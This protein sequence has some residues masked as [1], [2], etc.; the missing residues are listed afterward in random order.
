VCV[1]VWGQRVLEC[2]IKRI[3]GLWQSHAHAQPPRHTG[4]SRHATQM[5]KTAKTMAELEIDMNVAYE[6]SAMTEA[7]AKLTQLSGPGHVGLVNLGN[8]CYMNSVLQVCVCI[9]VC[10]RARREGRGC[11]Q[12][13]WC[14]RGRITLQR[15][16]LSPVC[17][18]CVLAVT[19]CG[20]HTR[21]HATTA[22]RAHASTHTHTHPHTS[23]HTHTV[24]HTP[25]TCAAHTHPHHT[26]HTHS[27][28][29]CFSQCLSC[30]SATPAPRP[31]SSAARP[32]TLLP[33]C[34]RSWPSS[35]WRWSRA[36]LESRRRCPRSSSP[37]RRQQRQRPHQRHPQ[38]RQRRRGASGSAAGRGARGGRRVRDGCAG[39]QQRAAS[40]LQGAGGQGPPRVFF[41]AS[42]GA[43]RC[44]A[45]CMHA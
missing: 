14:G 3:A 11:V 27:V 5:E 8:S 34:P 17:R 23:T 32:Q 9:C 24:S 40:G 15:P 21:T 41:W 4:K 38:R 36:A 28:D 6:F 43:A 42:A 35:A 25:H 13:G 44:V 33:T 1:D 45:A 10:V 29:R 19:I 31:P 16:A 18:A 22:G 26:P 20:A 30:R 7:G 39:G 12:H 37:A 2:W